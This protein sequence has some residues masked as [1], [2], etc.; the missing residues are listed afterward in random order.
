M[1]LTVKL[2][3]NIL[4]NSFRVLNGLTSKYSFLLQASISL[5]ESGSIS[6]TWEEVLCNSA[7]HFKYLTFNIN[8]FKFFVQWGIKAYYIHLTAFFLKFHNLVMIW[9]F[10]CITRQ[11]SGWN[12]ISVI[13]GSFQNNGKIKKLEEPWLSLLI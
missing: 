7:K 10:A 11:W 2:W 5:N 1:G 9:D 8:I 12:F 4:L 3:K 13:F 6:T